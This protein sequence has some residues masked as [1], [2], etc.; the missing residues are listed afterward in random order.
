MS[1]IAVIGAGAWGTA[2]AIVVGRSGRHEVN[3]WARE[4]EVSESIQ[5]DRVNALFLPGCTIPP[6][7]S[8]TMDMQQALAGAEIVIS[9]TPSHHCRRVFEHM[10]QWL[11]PHMLFV[12]ATKGIENDTLLRMSEVIQEIV[13]RLSG[14]TPRVAAMSGPTFALEVAQG[15]PT[16]LTAASTDPA[17]AATVQKELSDPGFRIYSS[18]D[19]IGVELGGALKNVIAI[20]AGICDGLGLGHNSIAALITRGLAEIT[21]L[22]VA[23]GAKPQTLAGLA[24]MGRARTTGDHCRNARHGRGR[25]AYDQRNPGPGQKTSRGNAHCRADAR[26]SERRPLTAR[27]HSGTDVASR[28]SRVTFGSRVD[29][30]GLKGLLGANH[31][32]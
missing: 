10:S 12:S 3:L 18:G 20:A 27:C 6:I 8:V 23:C 32:R 1:R 9:V 22:A 25:R 14:F 17:L 26:H 7:V 5:T 29:S 11:L 28:K 4:K 30:T 31:G 2:L 19:M 15:S 13:G 21:R 16:A 24:G